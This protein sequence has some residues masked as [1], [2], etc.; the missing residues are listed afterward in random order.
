MKRIRT[1]ALTGRAL[2]WAVQACMPNTGMSATHYWADTPDG[3]D[4][5]LIPPYTS[6]PRAAHP[7]IV[8]E[9][10]S[11]QKKHDGWWLAGIYNLNDDLEFI[12]LS[13]EHL[14]AAMRTYVHKVLGEA[15]EVPE[16]LL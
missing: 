15:V 1:H 6:D 11:V 4:D 9:D 8:R 13:H 12:Q 16:A 3:E 14:E 10:I 7:I 2:D 5:F